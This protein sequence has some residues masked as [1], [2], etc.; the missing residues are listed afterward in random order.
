[1]TADYSSIASL[2]QRANRVRELADAVDHPEASKSLREYA[3]E[4]DAWADRIDD[5]QIAQ[6]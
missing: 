5:D 4:L 1:M 6:R 2:R 3:D